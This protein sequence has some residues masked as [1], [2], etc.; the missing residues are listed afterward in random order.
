MLWEIVGYSEKWLQISTQPDN[1]IIDK[2]KRGKY[3]H[4]AKFTCYVECD[5]D[6]QAERVAIDAFDSFLK[7]IILASGIP[8]NINMDRPKRITSV[9]GDKIKNLK[10]NPHRK[11]SDSFL[12]ESFRAYTLPPFSTDE[13]YEWISVIERHREN[14]LFQKLVELYCRA[15]RLSKISKSAG[16]LDFIKIVE[17]FIDK[18]YRKEL[19]S[20]IS[21]QAAFEQ[22]NLFSV[23]F[24]NLLMKYFP[25]ISPPKKSKVTKNVTQM[26]F[27]KVPYSNRDLLDYVCKTSGFYE[28]ALRKKKAGLEGIINCVYSYWPKEKREVYSNE[29]FREHEKH[30]LEISKTLFK[31]RGGQAHIS[32]EIKVDRNVLMMCGSIAHYLLSELIKGNIVL[33]DKAVSKIQEEKK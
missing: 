21:Q 17:L 26:C 31:I 15:V 14:S 11:Y 18:K 28:W 24:S 16:Y 6:I 20:N 7:G 27:S 12:V 23:E 4:G 1:I 19:E 33:N 9:P 29:L 22:M 10:Y 2:Y 5:N 13:L 25:E 8:Y 3:V 32:E 30:I